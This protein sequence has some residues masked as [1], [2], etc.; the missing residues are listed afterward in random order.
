MSLTV[1]VP[2]RNEA[3][4]VG[5]LL[6]QLD[7][8]LRLANVN[9]D[10]LFVDDSTDETPEVID[11]L[12]RKVSIAVRV[13]HRD[14][15][16]GGLGGAVLAGLRSA[17]GT[18][19]VVMDGDL[20]HPPADVPVLYERALV[21]DVELVVASR[22]LPGGGADGL[23]GWSRRAVSAASTL[24]ARGLFPRRVGRCSDPMSGFFAVRRDAVDLDAI[25]TDGYKIL[26]PLLEHR[27][28]AVAEVPFRF[29]VRAAGTSKVCLREG[30]RYLR[31]LASLRIAGPRRQPAWSLPHAIA[32]QLSGHR[33]ANG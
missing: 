7:Y 1:V 33:A 31:L 25:R 26:L 29:G 2:T 20:Q 3:P 16:E 21:G 12:S 6:F 5:P 24:I 14:R 15:P 30:A 10:V 4:N 11:E 18:W 23:D 27:D 13:L 17:T 28:L 19:A 22:H 32:S 8:Q 9:A